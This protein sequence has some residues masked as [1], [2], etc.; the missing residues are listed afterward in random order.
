M[1]LVEHDVAFVARLA[2]RVT[3]LDLGRVDRRRDPRRG[4]RRPAVIAAY[5]GDGGPARRARKWHSL[6]SRLGGAGYGHERAARGGHL[7]R[8]RAGR[9]QDPA[10][11]GRRVFKPSRS[12]VP[13]E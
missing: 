7:A 10:D 4:P 1:L 5:L 8:G 12:L 6:E 11:Q 13:G 9:D 3:V 2:D